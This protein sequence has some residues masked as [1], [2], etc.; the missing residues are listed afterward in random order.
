MDGRHRRLPERWGHLHRLHDAR[1]PLAR[2]FLPTFELPGAAAQLGAEPTGS[3]PEP[4]LLNAE[5]RY[6]VLLEQLPAVTFMAAFEQGLSEIY[7]SPQ[8][9]ALLGYTVRE[10]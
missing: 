1:L 9:E 8:I 3:T 4:R 2:A 6:Q 5:A 10:W 7:V